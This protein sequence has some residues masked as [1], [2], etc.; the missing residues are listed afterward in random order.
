[1]NWSKN[2]PMGEVASVFPTEAE[3][4]SLTEGGQDGEVL[5]V[6]MIYRFF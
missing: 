4:V 5:G 1:M 3:R 6:F 2:E